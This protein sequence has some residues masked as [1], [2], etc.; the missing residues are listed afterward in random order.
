MMRLGFPFP[1]PRLSRMAALSLLPATAC[2]AQLPEP[3]LVLFGQVGDETTGDLLTGGGDITWTFT[4]TGG[5]ATIEVTAPLSDVPSSGD[6]F[7]Y[8]IEIPAESLLAGDTATP[9]TLR[10][11]GTRTATGGS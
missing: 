7:S 1:R 2:F 8:L 6:P 9:D 4:P 3:P 5:G 11:T 10:L